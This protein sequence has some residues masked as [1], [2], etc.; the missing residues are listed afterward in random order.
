MLGLDSSGQAGPPSGRY[1]AISAGRTHTCALTADGEAVCW[2][3]NGT[4][5]YGDLGKADPPPG[6]YTAISAGPDRTCALTA[7][8]EAVCWGDNVSG[9]GDPPPGRYTAIGTGC[10]L[11]GA[12]E[13]LCWSP[14]PNAPDG[15]YRGIGE[16]RN[17]SWRIVDILDRVW[18]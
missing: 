1:A 8:G 11:T 18:P 5:D 12:G 17:A 7:T 4:A 2:G 14:T 15:R 10:A 3:D 16:W 9:E 6:R 13:A